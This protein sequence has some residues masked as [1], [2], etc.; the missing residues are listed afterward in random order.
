M[1]LFDFPDKP[2]GTA[3]DLWRATL[4]LVWQLR[5]GA[6]TFRITGDQAVGTA[7]T[8]IRHGLTGAPGGVSFEPRAD[9]RWWAPRA[10]DATFV[11][12]QASAAV[13]GVVRVH[14]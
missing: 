9:C 2:V 4:D 8:A 3:A 11:Y 12:L 13:T 6:K 7:T 10:P 14:P 1:K 5:N